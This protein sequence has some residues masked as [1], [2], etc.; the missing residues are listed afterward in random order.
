VENEVVVVTCDGLVVWG[1]LS[2]TGEYL[3]FSA[4]DNDKVAYEALARFAVVTPMLAVTFHT[5][6]SSTD[7]LMTGV[8]RPD[9]VQEPSIYTNYVAA[10][11]VSYHKHFAARGLMPPFALLVVD[12]K[13]E[14]VSEEQVDPDN[15]VSR[16]DSCIFKLPFSSS[17]NCVAR[18][19]ASLVDHLHCTPNR[20]VIVQ[21]F[22]DSA[23][24]EV[25][26]FVVKGTILFGVLNFKGKGIPLFH[27]NSSGLQFLEALDLSTFG[28]DYATSKYVAQ[29]WTKTKTTLIAEIAS[30]PGLVLS[31]FNEFS[32]V[33]VEAPDTVV[34]R[35]DTQF[36]AQYRSIRQ[37]VLYRTFE[38]ARAQQQQP[39][40]F[41]RIDL[42]FWSAAGRFYVNEV[43]SFACGKM[44]SEIHRAPTARILSRLLF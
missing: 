1:A 9:H 39:A 7:F 13:G 32:R 16:Y 33:P 34:T 20:R 18:D 24:V 12:E 3:V 29:L 35:T 43:E 30:F 25:R 10:E 19:L 21:K 8:P 26:V 23:D 44:M 40:S 36:S 4:E 2:P 37:D 11:K 6:L 27:N 42:A 14:V 28:L 15:P 41:L 17:G 22:N 31:A 38:V 5:Y